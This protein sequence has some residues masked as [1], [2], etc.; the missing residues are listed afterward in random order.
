[1]VCER[2]ATI[3]QAR[4]NISCSCEWRADEHGLYQV[5][6]D[7]NDPRL[8][9]SKYNL[10]TPDESLRVIGTS[11]PMAHVLTANPDCVHFAIV[12]KQDLKRRKSI[13]DD[14]SSTRKRVRIDGNNQAESGPLRV[15]GDADLA[16]TSRS[17]YL[18]GALRMVRLTC[19][20]QSHRD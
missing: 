2:V 8:Q 18:A 20:Y 13:E 3:I 12:G 4:H 11:F 14:S 9:V 1:M 17:I 6:L 15:A 10:W 16:Y 19:I 5:N 7:K